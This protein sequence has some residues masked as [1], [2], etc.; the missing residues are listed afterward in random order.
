MI[1]RKGECR[2][3]RHSRQRGQCQQTYIT[4][5]WC[6]ANCM[7]TDKEPCL[8]VHVYN[9]DKLRR[10]S[11]GERT[12]RVTGC[13][14]NA[15]RRDKWITHVFVAVSTPFSNFTAS[16]TNLHS[17]S[18]RIAVARV[19]PIKSVALSCGAVALRSQCTS[20]C[21]VCAC[22]GIPPG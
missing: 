17:C 9:V 15:T 10:S 21:I 4:A 8:Q 14:H 6:Y 12:A 3:P 22:M 7:Y 11:E 13:V 2:A 20:S 1:F 19:V 16:I 5:Q 18:V